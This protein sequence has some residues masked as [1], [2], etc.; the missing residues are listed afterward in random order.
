YEFLRHLEHILQMEN[1]L[2]THTVPAESDRRGLVA[3]RMRCET[4]EIF[5]GE[6][7]SQ[8]SNV[9]RIFERVFGSG[10]V[11]QSEV[12][13]AKDGVESGSDSMGLDA[14]SQPIDDANANQPAAAALSSRDEY[15]AQLHDAIQ[16]ETDFRHQLGA[17]R[18]RWSHS[19]EEIRTAELDGIL[20]VQRAKRAQTAL[21]EASIEIALD[22][23][24]EDLERRYNTKIERLR[25]AVI[26]LGKLGGGAID[27]GSDLDLVLVYDDPNKALELPPETAEAEFYS[28]VAEIFVTTLSSMTRDG[29]IYR[30]DLRLRPYGKNGQSV[31]SAP[32]FVE[33]VRASAAIWELLAYVKIRAV[34]GEMNFARELEQSIR[35]IIHTRA[36]SI[37]PS[38]LANETRRVRT[39]L[40]NEK[41]HVRR[42]KDVDIKYGPGGMLD[43]YFA[44][45]YL[46]LRDNIPD[47]S[48]DRS[49]DF[50]LGVLRETGSL[51]AADHEV[52]LD[53]YRFLSALDHDLRL[54]I[55][56]TTRLPTANQKALD[57]VSQRMGLASAAELVERL[58]IH[59][60]NIRS[61]FD[62]ILSAPL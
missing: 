10:D 38:D 14:G 41:V 19:I 48:E 5:D 59:R 25:I 46:Q 1:G 51:S 43:I 13:A 53:G 52:L 35:E 32:A 11:L 26:G 2:Q 6:I 44:M 55:G 62:K 7:D 18:R 16:K 40:E 39:L 49:T 61:S 34:G 27:Y 17:F 29:S 56:R 42:S 4:S 50:M 58:T 37:D 12:P 31:I 9:H 15:F 21:A 47:R 22:L 36:G 8:T 57:V 28:R 3:L 33:Y 23:A 54:T 20:D 45:R 60:L 30:I 24:H